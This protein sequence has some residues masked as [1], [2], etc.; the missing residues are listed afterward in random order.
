MKTELLDQLRSANITKVE[1]FYSGS[2]DEGYINEITTIGAEVNS[3]TQGDLET[4]FWDYVLDRSNASGFHNDE[5]GC[6]TIIWDVT[7]D[8]FVVHHTQYFRSEKDF[9]PEEIIIEDDE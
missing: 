1:A 3:E 2:G 5:G 6:G 9:E 4:F 8:K 7:A